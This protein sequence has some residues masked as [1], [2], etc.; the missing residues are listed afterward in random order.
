MYKRPLESMVRISGSCFARKSAS[1]GFAPASGK[2][3]LT[4]SL[5]KGAVIMK[6][7]SS[8]NMTSMY[9]TTLISPINRRRRCDV[10]ICLTLHPGGSVT[11]QDG[12]EL[13]Y[14]RIEAQLQAADLIGE[15]VVGDHGGDGGKQTHGRG[16]Q[17]FGNAGR[18]RRER[19]LLHIA[20]I[21]ERRHDAPDRAEQTHVRT[22]RA[23]R[24]QDRQVFLQAIQLAQ[25]RNPHRAPRAV[26]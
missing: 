12:G 2:S 18:D 5:S 22:G 21:V 1:I 13:F 17:R 26:Q 6:M 16:D 14:K 3:T 24:G 15:A 19:R 10:G 25:L 4:P 8:T 20:Q 7:I 9:G 23:D 11:L